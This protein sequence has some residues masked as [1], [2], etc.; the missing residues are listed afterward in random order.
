MWFLGPPC[1]TGT[2]LRSGGTARRRP[3]PS[4]RP[5]NASVQINLLPVTPHPWVFRLSPCAGCSPAL[6]G[7]GGPWR[8][9][10]GG[11]GPHPRRFCA[12]PYPFHP[13]N[14]SGFG[15]MQGGLVSVLGC[16]SCCCFLA[17]QLGVKLG[18]VC[19]GVPAVVA[20]PVPGVRPRWAASS[21]RR[22]AADPPLRLHFQR[23]NP[24]PSWLG[25]AGTGEIK[26]LYR[27]WMSRWLHGVPVAILALPGE[28][29]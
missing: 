4:P 7:L 28:P 22:A 2:P 15:G 27:T 29:G 6:S 14:M 3:R 18:G 26:G 5:P 25:S 13:W 19:G 21:G 23:A 20:L 11:S 8:G 17:A 10:A 1:P 24:A 16:T 12:A 9:G